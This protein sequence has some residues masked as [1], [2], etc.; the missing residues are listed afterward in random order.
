MVLDCGKEYLQGPWGL[1]LVEIDVCPTSKLTHQN[2][3]RAE[4]T[5]F[6]SKNHVWTLLAQSAE[7][8]SWWKEC[9]YAEENLCKR[10]ASATLLLSPGEL[11]TGVSSSTN[12][13]PS[14]GWKFW[15]HIAH[16]ERKLLKVKARSIILLLCLLYVKYQVKLEV[17]Y[18]VG[19]M[20]DLLAWQANFHEQVKRCNS[21]QYKLNLRITSWRLTMKLFFNLWTN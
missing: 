15:V 12:Y 19:V 6:T 1:K 17:D 10:V 2:K 21:G 8:A 16:K 13:I 7:P 18:T 14:F 5:S 9:L 20:H 4:R 11:F 3:D